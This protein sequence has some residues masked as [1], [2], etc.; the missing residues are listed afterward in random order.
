M[1]IREK[2]D[3]LNEAK[4]KRQELLEKGMNLEDYKLL[5]QMLE[6]SKEIYGEDSNYTI[7][8]L[9][10]F[11]SS[12]KYIGKYEE[13]IDSLSKAREIILNKFSKNVEYATVTLN[14][15]EVYR[16]KGDLDKIE[17][18]YFEVIDIYNN[19][20]YLDKLEYEYASVYNNLALYY[21]DIFNFEKAREYGYKSYNILKDK[22]E[23]RIQL[24]TT[25]NNLA[26]ADRMLGDIKKSDEEIE[27][28]LDIL[29]KEVGKA[30]PTYSAVLNN[31]AISLFNT[32]NTDKALE[33]MDYCLFITE[34][35]FGRDSLNYIKLKENYDMINEVNKMKDNI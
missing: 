22:E 4:I 20:D 17:S 33:I 18:L 32:G 24:A 30:H 8:L 1:T 21:Q 23:Y 15:A 10:E 19:Q 14:L 27:E 29:D 12:C 28:A 31:L 26:I 11:G 9:S 5:K 3:F 6:I 16:F 25:L 7:S 34:S 2:L 13:G 35:A